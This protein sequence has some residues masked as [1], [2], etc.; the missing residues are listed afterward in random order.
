MRDAPPGPPNITKT[1][2]VVVVLA[3]AAILVLADIG[4]S[5]VLPEVPSQI[6][7]TTHFQAHR[8]QLNELVRTLGEDEQVAELTQDEGVGYNDESHT[9]LSHNRV[10]R[11]RSLLEQVALP[12]YE[13][14]VRRKEGTVTVDLA[15]YGLAP[16]GTAVGY[17]HSKKPLRPLVEHIDDPG[18]APYSEIYYRHLYGNWYVYHESW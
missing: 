15:G 10:S 5:T 8:G 16:S 6:E 2:T 18:D 1:V 3:I 9:S 11:Y 17:K 7:L 4:L 12:E 14:W 13:V